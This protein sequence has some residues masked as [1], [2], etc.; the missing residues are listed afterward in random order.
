MVSLRALE[1]ED[2]DT[3][4]SWITSADEL[5]QWS[6]PWDF[7]WPLDAAQLR[8]DLAVVRERRRLFAAIADDGQELIGHAMLTFQ[9]EHRLGVIGR[10]LLDPHRRGGGL[11]TAVMREVVRLGFDRFGLHRL[12]LAVYVFNRTAIACYQRVGFVIEG[13]LR[14]STRGSDGYWDA[15]LMALLEAEY[16]M[17]GAPAVGGGLVVRPA[18]FTDAA[19]LAR[20]LTELGYT[21]DA[22][23]AAA[24]L[25][26]WAGDPRGTVL[27]AVLDGLR[28]GSSQLMPFPTCTGPGHSSAW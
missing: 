14:G 2:C 28:P 12:Q 25:T 11:G 19:A 4:L 22:E 26:A 6:G 17:A 1:P 7:R 13:R 15:Y 5:F 27:V 9:P 18:R 23:P 20:L 10:V 21:Q 16:R 8:R 3:V 24:Q